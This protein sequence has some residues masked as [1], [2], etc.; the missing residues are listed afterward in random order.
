[1]KVP[2]NKAGSG[3]GVLGEYVSAISPDQAGLLLH[4]LTDALLGRA[5]LP[6]SWRRASVTLIPELAGAVLAKHYRPITVLPVL[7]KLALRCCL[8]AAWSFLEL[9]SQASH[10]FRTGF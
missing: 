10:G 9:D 6:R 3:D 8:S 5:E 2:K 1:M 4:L 7:Q